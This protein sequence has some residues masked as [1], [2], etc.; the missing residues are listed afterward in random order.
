MTMAISR[1]KIDDK[2]RITLPN[3]FL[4]ANGIEQGT[5][6]VI[7]PIYNNNRACKLEFENDNKGTFEGLGKTEPKD[8]GSVS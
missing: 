6:V 8:E 5:Y 3:H 4:K 7:C 2:G 1:V